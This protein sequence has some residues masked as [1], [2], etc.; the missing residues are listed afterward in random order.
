M[1][2]PIAEIMDLHEVDH[3]DAKE[4]HRPLHLFDARLFPIS[5][6]FRRDE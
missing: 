2:L 5:P 1:D 4:L 6:D 3:A